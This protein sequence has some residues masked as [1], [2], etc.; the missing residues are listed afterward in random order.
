MSKGLNKVILIGNIGKDPELKITQGQSSV[1][2]ISL[3]TSSSWKDK[4]TG[5]ICE[6]TEWHRVVFFNKLAQIVCEYTTKGS[7]VCIEGKLRTRKW[8]DNNGVDRYITE[9]IAEEMVLLD[10]VETS[11]KPSETQNNPYTSVTLDNGDIL[12]E[13]D[14]PF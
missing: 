8:K 12:Y 13:E 10:R 3:A 5:K 7:R 4:A 11:G 14:D 2:N 6:H 1:A 9:V